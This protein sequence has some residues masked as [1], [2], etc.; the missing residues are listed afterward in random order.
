MTM[1][2]SFTVRCALCGAE[3]VFDEILSTSSVGSSDLDTRSPAMRRA[4][5]EAQ[6]QRCSGCGYCASDISTS[7]PDASEVINGQEYR[8][9]LND[10]TYPEPANSFLC[11]S[12]LLDRELRNNHAESA[13]ARIKAAWVCDDYNYTT[14]AIA[15]R[16]MAE[17]NL[18]V[19][20]ARNLN[21]AVQDE[22]NVAIRV[23]LLRR[24]KQVYA[25]RKLISGRR[26][27]ITDDLIK[28]IL[29]YQTELLD[30]N[31]FSRHT[32]AEARSRLKQHDSEVVTDSESNVLAKASID[33]KQEPSSGSSSEEPDVKERQTNTETIWSEFDVRD[34]T[35]EDYQREKANEKIRAQL[36]KSMDVL[37]KDGIGAAREYLENEIKIEIEAKKN[38]KRWNEII[39]IAGVVLVTP[40]L[41]R[42][43][44]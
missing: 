25:A 15:C 32:I 19:A 14:Q 22:T 35:W 1:V 29:D 40:C 36:Q 26:G 20:E 6:V 12:I 17:I 34:F 44:M 42:V 8:V 18:A 13:W 41:L 11:Q 37:H 43:Q 30:K 10:P 3:T 27:K 33:S 38:K 9:Q 39:K 16:R 7:H 21:P 23:D 2:D 28:C 31:D 4:V 5:L 24:S